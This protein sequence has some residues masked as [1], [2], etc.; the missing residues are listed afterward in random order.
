MKAI[1]ALNSEQER[2]TELMRV[3]GRTGLTLAPM[4]RA[5][6]EALDKA[7]GAVSGSLSAFLMA[8]FRRRQTS[9]RGSPRLPA[10]LQINGRRLARSG[11]NGLRKNSIGQPNLPLSIFGTASNTIFD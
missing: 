11:R 7:L 5:G 4:L 8:A 1:A 2:A 9:T 10:T 3:F 6:P